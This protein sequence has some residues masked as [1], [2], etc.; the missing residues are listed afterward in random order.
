MEKD[1]DE[2]LIPDGDYR[3]ALN[4]EVINSEGSDVGSVQNSFSN[5]KL[6][7]LDLGENVYTLSEFEDKSRNKLYWHVK[8]DSGCYLLEWDDNSQSVSYVL[9][10]TRTGSERVLDLDENY[11]I[12][13]LDKIINDNVE[14]DLF[15]WTDNNMEVCCINIERAKRYGTNGFDIEDISLIKKPPRFAPTTTLFYNGKEGNNIEEKFSLFAYRYQYLDNEWSPLSSFT[16]YKFSPKPYNI[17]Y[18][19]LDNVGMVNAFNAVN[20]AFNTGDRRVKAVQIITKE[21]N[22]NALHVIETFDK[23]KEGWA[24]NSIQNLQFSNNKSY[25]QLPS[26]EWG[27]TSDNIPRKSGSLALVNNRLILGNNLEGYNIV[28]GDK[29]KI[30]PDY[31]VSLKSIALNKGDDFALAMSD[32]SGSNTVTLS[33]T[34]G[35][36]LKRGYS[37]TFSFNIAKTTTFVNTIVYNNSFQFVLTKDYVNLQELFLDADFVSFTNIII[38]DFALNYDGVLGAGEAVVAPPVLSVF[39]TGL[40]SAGFSVSPFTYNTSP[41][42]TVQTQYLYFK[43]STTFSLL[44]ASSSA[45]CKSNRDYEAGLVY[46]DDKS[47]ETVTLTCPDNSIYIPNNKSG[48]K[49]SLSVQ[50][51]NPPPYFADRFKLVVKTPMLSYHTLAVNNFYID[52]PYVWIKLEGSNIDKVKTGEYLILKSRFGEVQD[53][54]IKTK[55]LEISEKAKDFIS[56]SPTIEPAGY[57][58]KIKPNGFDMNQ[59]ENEIYLDTQSHRSMYSFPTVYLDLHTVDG[60]KQKLYPG[61]NIKL[62]FLCRYN[63]DDGWSNQLYEESYPIQR[64]YNNVEEWF[65]ENVSGNSLK[66]TEDSDYIDKVSVVVGDIVVV[67]APNGIKTQVFTSNPSGKEYMKV[68]GLKDTSS[69]ERF[70]HLE[71]SIEIRV[72][73]GDYIFET[74]PKRSVDQDLFFQ[75]E[76]TFEVLNGNHQGNVQNQNG[77]A[78]PCIIDLDYF[79]CF[80]QGNGVESY[81]VK[82]AFNKPYLNIDSRPTSTLAEEYKEVRRLSDLSHSETYVESTNRNGLNEFNLSRGNIK[83]LDKGYGAISKLLQ[84]N[85]NLLVFQTKKVSQVLYEKDEIK[86]AEGSSSLIAVDYVLGRQIPYVGENGCQNPESV[87]ALDRQVYYANVDYGAIMRLANDGTNTLVKGMTSF[88]RN[89]FIERP[90][91]KVL[92]GIDPYFNKYVVSVGDEPVSVLELQCGNIINKHSINTAFSYHLKLNE[93]S[94]DIVLN[95]LVSGG[96]ATIQAL[97]NG[98][99]TVVSNITG[100]GVLTIP[101]TSLYIDTVIVTVTPVSGNITFEITNNCPIGKPLK[102]VSIVLGDSLD[103]G[104]SITN[105][106]KWDGTP[107][108]ETLDT[109]LETPLTRFASETGTEG[110]GKF[111]LRGSTV[112][113]Q[114]YSNAG[115][116]GSFD[117]TKLNRL[118]YLISPTAYTEADVNTI[119]SLATFPAVTASVENISNVVNSASFNFTKTTD[120]QILYL[121][122]DYTDRNIAL[123]ND[124]FTVNNAGT[125]ICNVLLNDTISGTPTVTI[126]TAPTNGTAVVNVD[127]TITY[128]HDGTATLTDSY[129]YQVSTGIAT[130]TATVNITVNASGIPPAATQSFYYEGWYGI[131]GPQGI[132]SYLDAYGSTQYE[133]GLY[134]GE[135]RLITAQ[136]ILSVENAGACTVTA[137]PVIT[138]TR[139]NISNPTSISKCAGA[140]PGS[141]PNVV[142]VAS[143]PIMVGDPIYVYEDLHVLFNGDGRWYST[144]GPFSMRINSNGAVLEIDDS[145]NVLAPE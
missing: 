94:G 83:E 12:T 100:S 44:K 55:V 68:V 71:A 42:T 39:T 14:D 144:S 17:D 86:T 43:N 128:V 113:I 53:T 121:I 80:A 112:N 99:V 64:E 29:K 120:A 74:E 127:K 34:A 61:N 75:T 81:Q 51:N 63:Y 13:G 48:H 82:D 46:Y 30:K 8:S 108:Y 73:M 20:I 129:V 32:V 1:T 90:N 47:R 87:K 3:D 85:N 104:K 145:C 21:S 4:I 6:T 79:N 125:Y 92:G 105:R 102:V 38:N 56:S 119:L 16:N 118:G 25:R 33:N 132:V 62:R 66:G 36:L 97:F 103:S 122:W 136:S 18:Y 41:V 2:R 109:F 96:N 69:R 35:L 65:V 135:C 45:S 88:F 141:Y 130:A 126:L 11:L 134:S 70:N 110:Q 138:S 19:T 28:D 124:A 72:S 115:Q 84:Y 101:R 59:E 114:S 140:I 24:D 111:P 7:S 5:R 133:T 15:L 27:R 139:L 143:L 142:F 31:N 58:M 52:G 91:A 98:N 67:T 117:I 77:A 93:L 78:T 49:N 107:Y 54:I 40:N 37:I 137:P 10:D 26:S 106:F 89:L 123:V 23:A 60:V 131:S 76:Q 50:I 9:K 57:Y 95:Y 22:S 116:Q